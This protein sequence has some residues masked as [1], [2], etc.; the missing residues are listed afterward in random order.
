MHPL[1]GKYRTFGIIWP[2]D[3]QNKA[4]FDKKARKERCGST[5]PKGA[6]HHGRF[7][8]AN[9]TYA[10]LALKPQFFFGFGN[11]ALREKSISSLQA[12]FCNNSKMQNYENLKADPTKWAHTFTQPQTNPN[13]APFRY[14]VQNVL[15][16]KKIFD[17]LWCQCHVLSH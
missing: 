11:I 10:G 6:S 5:R 3:I 15:V 8:G 16:H 9:R 7:Y 13:E 1:H 2:V 17:I 14:P 12:I 4:N